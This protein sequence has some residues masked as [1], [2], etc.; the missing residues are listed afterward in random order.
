MFMG[1]MT[2]GG[3]L[4]AADLTP[5]LNS[6][7]KPV[8]TQSGWTFTFAPYFWAAGMKGDIAQFGLPAVHVDESFSDILQDLDF[9]FMAA[10]EARYDRYSIFG[11]IIYAKVSQDAHTPRGIFANNIEVTSKT[12]AGLLGAGY[13]L[14]DEPSGHLD[15]VGGARVW[16]VDTK[17]SF[18]G[19]LLG[20]VSR[21]DNATWVDAVA[22]LKGN[23]FFTPQIYLTGW[24]LVGGGG[25][26]VDWD[27]AAGLGY[28]FNNRISAIAGY[29][30]LGVDYNHD[31]FEFNIVQQGPILG[32]A[33]H[34]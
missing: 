17:I 18:N 33:I 1:A 27:V 14:I 32:L 29:R 22:G 13:A 10:G 6:E 4:Q 31:N 24:G 21:D 11:D 34:F 9:G 25:A 12:F 2:V 7:A 3:S 15:I 19:G 16:S 28:K 8:A 26:D 23:Y 20:G 5:L 30:A